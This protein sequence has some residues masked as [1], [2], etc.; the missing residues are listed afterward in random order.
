M[1][2][3]I[4]ISMLIF[5][6]VFALCGSISNSIG[7]GF[8]CAVSMTYCWITWWSEFVIKSQNN[9]KTSVSTKVSDEE[10]VYKI[11]K[12]FNLEGKKIIIISE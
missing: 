6:F 10:L 5:I 7:V 3:L 8:I 1:F 9:I 4:I 2:E 12:E 11:K